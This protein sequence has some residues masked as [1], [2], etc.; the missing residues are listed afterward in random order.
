MFDFYF[1]LWKVRTHHIGGIEPW[2]SFDIGKTTEVIKIGCHA[3][4][5]DRDYFNDPTQWIKFHTYLVLTTKFWPSALIQLKKK[6]LRDGARVKKGSNCDSVQLPCR[7]SNPRSKNF[8]GYSGIRTQ[9]QLRWGRDSNLT[10]G[11]DSNPRPNMHNCQVGSRTWA[12]VQLQL[13]MNRLGP[14]FEPCNSV[15][16]PWE[17]QSGIEPCN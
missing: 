8:I 15:Q 16:M 7:E 17:T 4:L 11:R 1:N 10:W 12:T 14:R 6:K 9:L 13:R 3:Y 5:V 2:T